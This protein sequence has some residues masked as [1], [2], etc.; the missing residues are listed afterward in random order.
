MGVR[1][2][3]SPF[4]Y[5]HIDVSS[6]FWQLQGKLLWFLSVVLGIEPRASQVRKLIYHS[7]VL[8]AWKVLTVHGQASVMI[9][10]SFLVNWNGMTGYCE[11]VHLFKSLAHQSPWWL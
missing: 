9:F 2:F 11:I 7:G 4:T 5:L 6:N 8:P 10:L 1:Y 3:V